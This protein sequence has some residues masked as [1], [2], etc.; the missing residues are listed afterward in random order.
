[1]W[2]FI[3]WGQRWGA[4]RRSTNPPGAD[5]LPALGLLALQHRHVVHGGHPPDDPLLRTSV[6]GVVTA[7][8]NR[9]CAACLLMPSTLPIAAEM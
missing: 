6:A 3:R 5:D 1:V 9:C 2:A 7:A 4:A 8:L